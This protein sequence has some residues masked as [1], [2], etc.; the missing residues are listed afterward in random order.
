MSILAWLTVLS[1]QSYMM[2]YGNHTLYT[3]ILVFIN[4]NLAQNM[5]NNLNILLHVVFVFL[6]YEHSR[7]GMLLLSAPAI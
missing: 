4:N 7:Y 5:Q 3:N 6:N 1:S 2:H